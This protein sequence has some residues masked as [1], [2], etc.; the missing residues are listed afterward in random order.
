M[1]RAAALAALLAL[2]ACAN[3]V[4]SARD[5][6]DDG[7]IPGGLA[8]PEQALLPGDHALWQ[9]LNRTEQRRALAFLADGSTVRSS[10]RLD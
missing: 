8:L 6:G 4:D 2:A 3:V 1:T 10:L 7:R 5:I 9:Q